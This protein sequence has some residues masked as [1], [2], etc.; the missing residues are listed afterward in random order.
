MREGGREEERE[1]V[2]AYRCPDNASLTC[3]VKQK[4][5]PVN[6]KQEKSSLGTLCT[7]KHFI[8]ILL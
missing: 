4:K 6:Y 3:M 7:L 8:I 1:R 2:T 5:E